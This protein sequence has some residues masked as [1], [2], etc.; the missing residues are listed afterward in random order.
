MSDEKISFAI[1]L[2]LCCFASDWSDISNESICYY[3]ALE[4]L[5]L[6]GEHLHVAMSL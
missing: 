6:S 5:P 1:A 4:K 3:A 2:C